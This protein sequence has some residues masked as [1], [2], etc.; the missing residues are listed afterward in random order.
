MQT[1]NELSSEALF[2]ET[3]NL[4]NKGDLA[5]AVANCRRAI[6]TDP[7][8]VSSTALLGAILIKTKEPVE[9]EKHL[10]KA[11][12][13]AP[14]F[15]KPHEDLG[16]LLLEADCSTEAVTCLEKAT[17]LDPKSEKAFY[18]LGKAYAKIGDG[19]KSDAAYEKSFGLNPERKKLAHAAEHHKAGRFKEAEVLYRETLRDYPN[20]VDA[21][22]MLAGIVASQ[23]FVE[24]A[25]SLFRR[26]LSL[27]PDY[28]LAFLDLGMLLQE[29]HRYAEAI[30]CFARTAALEPKTPKPHYF[31]ASILAQVGKTSSALKAYQHVLE[32]SPKHAG[33]LLGIGHTLKTIGKQEEAIDAYRNCINLRPDNGE[34]YW[35]LAN[36]KT[37]KLTSEDIN[38]MESAIDSGEEINDV[39]KANFL[40]AIAKAKED[41]GSFKDA[42][43]YYCEGNGLQRSL[44]YYDPVDTESTNNDLI[45][46]FD[47]NFLTK[48]IESG[49][50][51][52]APIFIVGLPR[53]GSTLIEQ[54]LASHSMVE[55]TSE[56][57]YLGRV[58]TSL[59][60][61]RADGIN[62]PQAV[63]ELSSN[64]LEALGQQYLSKAKF[65]R[66]SD[67]P[68]F[69]DKNPNN[70]ASIGFIHKI[71]PNAKII[72]ARRY[73]L[74][75]TFSCYRQLFAKGQTFVYDL[76]D[77][78][79]YYIQYLRMMDHWHDVLPGRVLTVQY[80]DLVFNL[81][82][83]VR[84]LLEYCELPWEESCLKFY[85]TDRPVRTASS[86]QVRQ[87]VYTN[88]VHYWRN[89]ED[90]LT[91]LI[92]VLDPVL[93][94]F[95]HYE[96]INRV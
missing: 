30:E 39:S 81:E 51:D 68:R 5:G 90:E 9:A 49:C 74:D 12:D 21:M 36:L 72:D 58:A 11:V 88:S 28:G 84:K 71:L 42:W 57:P 40:F 80:E 10:R 78:G 70:F 89:Y 95:Q 43:K 29:Q 63:S 48:N 52:A 2:K 94:R 38:R 14:T 83:Y 33:A 24:E 50:K 32:L 66:Q 55:G 44:E 17:R 6:A 60:R 35:S 54:I 4:I 46:V 25:E 65:N 19:Q 34:V 41:A 18:L 69:I 77:I 20:N 13:L 85:E 23:S 37:Y 47:K 86:E 3:I 15:A 26:A 31:L 67:K 56:L 73:P 45:K 27:A 87:P 75:S 64:H 53:S 92:E 76:T 7:S 82:D 91:E 22:R 61:N 8:D 96:H 93:P 1:T 16:Y 59:N 62:Y 79:E